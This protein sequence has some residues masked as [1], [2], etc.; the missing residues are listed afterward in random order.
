MTEL[1]PDAENLI[2]AASGGDDPST[3]DAERV[4]TKLA[5]RLALAAAAATTAATAPAQAI[6]ASTTA[7]PAAAS[8]SSPI[9]AGA[10]ALAG[11]TATIGSTKAGF[12]L[13][14]KLL[15]AL[16]L[17]GGTAVLGA[18]QLLS[19]PSHSVVSRPV[20]TTRIHQDANARNQ[21][22][23][24]TQIGTQQQAS[25]HQQINAPLPTKQDQTASGHNSAPH[26]VA[27]KAATAVPEATPAPPSSSPPTAPS[28]GKSASFPTAGSVAEEAALLRRARTALANGATSEAATLLERHRVLFPQGA[29]IEER[30]AT[31]VM[32]HCASGRN[33][34]TD[35]R[36]A[37]FLSAYPLSPL[38]NP[39]RRACTRNEF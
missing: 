14:G 15:L 26:V 5:T 27:Q 25:A 21:S 24:Q 39:V 11:T 31:Q 4:R 2:L 19:P 36:A 23:A 10:A 3:L 38:A 6:S 30:T 37:E 18:H 17:G 7:L 20:P 33:A 12:F 28:P 16:A 1:N 29:L 32:A 34:A 35:R 13:S 9:A 22:T 8:S